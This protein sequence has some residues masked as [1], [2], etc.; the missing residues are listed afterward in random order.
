MRIVKVSVRAPDAN[1]AA[2][3]D[4]TLASRRTPT[5]GFVSQFPD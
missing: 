4:R 3:A 5:H 2:P 1:G